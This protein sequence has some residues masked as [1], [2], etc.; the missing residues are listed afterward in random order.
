MQRGNYTVVQCDDL[1]VICIHWE[2]FLNAQANGDG[3]KQTLVNLSKRCLHNSLIG[4]YG[5]NSVLERGLILN[6]N[7]SQFVKWIKPKDIFDH[8]IQH[9]DLPVGE[10]KDEFFIDM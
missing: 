9:P 1:H 7:G 5:M 4:R 8:D 3:F 10:L 2:S 6:W